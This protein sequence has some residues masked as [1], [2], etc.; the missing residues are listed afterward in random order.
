MFSVQGGEVEFVSKMIEESRHLG[1]RIKIFSSMIGHKKN[2]N[3]LKEKL[4]NLPEVKN[5][6]V[7]ELCQGRTM[8]WVLGWTFDPQINLN[9]KSVRM[10]SKMAEKQK[11]PIFFNYPTSFD[12]V[13]ICTSLKLWL[14]TLNI[15]VFKEGK[16]SE[17]SAYLRLK[18][19]KTEWRGQRA[20]RRA[21]EPSSKRLKTSEEELQLDCQLYLHQAENFVTF[22]FV[23]LDGLVGKNGMAELV[24]CVKRK[25]N[26]V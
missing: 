13:E 10:E 8:R 19:T 3:L 2:V 9:L 21:Q 17:K 15:E 16:T 23:F 11:A 4:Q 6:V 14:S 7:T 20:K 24:Q 12:C 25:L 26:V 5:F 18:T 22:Q 1:H